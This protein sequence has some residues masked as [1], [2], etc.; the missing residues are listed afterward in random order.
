MKDARYYDTKGHPHTVDFRYR[1][2]RYEIYV[3]GK[4]YGSADDRE[5]V[6]DAVK[7]L[8]AYKGWTS[9]KPQK[10]PA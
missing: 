9:S 5:D 3:D 7:D 4:Y 10:N 6:Y 1:Y 8:V 2:M